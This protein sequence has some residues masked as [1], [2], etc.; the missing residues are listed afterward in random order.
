M[1]NLIKSIMEQLGVLQS[2][3]QPNELIKSLPNGQWAIL[4]KAVANVPKG[5]CTCGAHK[6][7]NNNLHYDWC[8]GLKAGAGASGKHAASNTKFTEL[9]NNLNSHIKA[10]RAGQPADVAGARGAIRSYAL[11][12]PKGQID[13][14][15]LG[16]LR[17]KSDKFT[18]PTGSPYK[19]PQAARPITHEDMEEIISHHVGDAPDLKHIYDNNGGDGAIETLGRQTG[20]D[21]L[22]EVS[23][24]KAS[25]KNAKIPASIADLMRPGHGVVDD[26][27]NYIE[28]DYK[29]THA[30]PQY[31][32]E[33][34]Q[35]HDALTHMGQY[36]DHAKIMKELD[37]AA[38]KRAV[39]RFKKHHGIK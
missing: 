30:D 21:G 26:N 7:P 24:Y 19:R 10:S 25:F 31:Q 12:L 2:N 29:D 15:H 22:N 20:A 37:D 23:R 17:E 6:T 1:D 16:K 4:Q 27:G 8:D 14:G 3:R 32:K 36:A 28:G 33:V 5:S 18:A 11:G 38:A 39:H 9:F 35:A 34:E 13:L